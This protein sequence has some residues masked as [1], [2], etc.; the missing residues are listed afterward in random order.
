MPPKNKKKGQKPQKPAAF[1]EAALSQLT[2]KIESSL[3]Q[4]KEQ[5]PEKRKRN[6]HDSKDSTPNKRRAQEPKGSKHQPKKAAKES[7]S[8]LLDEIRL[9]G[10]DEADLDLI[11]GVDSDAE[12]GQ[13]NAGKPS[14][15]VDKSFQKELAKFASGLGFEKVREESVAADDEPEEEVEGEDEDEEDLEEVSSFSDDEDA[16]GQPTTALEL[17]QAPE[18]PQNKKMKGKLEFEARPDWHAADLDELPPPTSDDIR[19]FSAAINN[20]KTYAQSL[21]EADATTY[22]AMVASSS[23]Q[24]FMS[25]IM[26]SGTMSDKVSAL[27]LAIQESPVHSIKA[28]ENL[29]GLAGKK[30]RG[31]AI[32]ALGALV[33]LLGNGV[34]LPSDRRLRPFNMQP[35]LL[36]ALQKHSANFWKPGQNLPGKL[37]KAHLIVWVFEDWL[38]D[39]YFRVIQ[40]LEVWCNDE[41]EYSRSRSLD[42]VFGLLR[43]K[44]E[45]EAN[46]LRLLVNKLGDRERKIASRASYLLL[47][48]LNIHPG[49]KPVVISTMEQEVILRPGQSLRTKYYAVNTLNQTILSSKEP[50]VAET[51]VRIYF[52]LFVSLLKMGVLGVGAPAEVN[53]TSDAKQGKRKNFKKSKPNAAPAAGAESET[54]EKL[55]SAILTGVNRAIPFAM[56]DESTLEKHIDT[57]FKITH[58]SNFN[59]SIQALMLIQ[60]L[61]ISKHLVVDRFY[62]TLYESLLDPRLVTSS[63]QSMYLNL[64]FRSLKNDVDVRRVKA[65]VKRMLQ[66]IHLHQAPFVCGILFMIAQLENTFPDL[67]TLINEPEEDLDDGEEV[68]RDVPTDAAVEGETPAK[69]PQRPSTAYDGR[70][71][72]PQYSNAQNSCL[73]EVMPYFHHFHPSVAVFAANILARQKDLPKPELANHTLMHFLDKFV[74]RNPKATDGKRG[75][76]IMQPVLATGSAANANA[77]SKQQA[78]VNSAAFW[79]KKQEDIAAEDVFFHE[80]FNQVG[81]PAQAATKAAKAKKATA[82]DDEEEEAEEE[83]WEALVNSRPEIGGEDDEDVDLDMGSDDESDLADLLN[84]SDDDEDDDVSLGSEVDGVDEA[85]E[86]VSDD[87]EDGGVWVDADASEDSDTELTDKKKKRMS[88]KEFK[89][90][91]TFASA[92]DY[93]EMLAAE[94]MDY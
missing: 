33:D 25:T 13:A 75:G 86:A 46:L 31:Q 51:L 17:P 74:Y 3:G 48:L 68:Y 57:L 82:E 37:T 69:E 7:S 38:K 83:I 89:S 35:G 73:W 18:K 59:T 19:N 11:T 67:K 87:G 15:D 61:S 36:G 85:D 54:A 44:P 39:A 10:G 42:F 62:R 90:L 27:T 91:P 94:E 12:D 1:N 92:D 64:L 32:A 47:Q 55:V 81:K 52:E 20:L 80:Y 23:T 45:Q 78:T 84:I 50:S 21:L 26:S 9:L 60:Q 49:M 93:A 5:R 70:K 34:L 4:P 56:T 28:L 22:S 76:S 43:D 79:N 77:G 58:S 24:K 2:A 72:D 66:V 29:I 6:D 16:A 41:I 53:G 8:S 14:A 71:R 30:S 63:K 40:L 65:F 88:R